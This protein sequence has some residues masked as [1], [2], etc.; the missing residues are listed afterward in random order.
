MEKALDYKG[1]SVGLTAMES[2]VV[3]KLNTCDE[4]DERHYSHIDDLVTSTGIEINQLRG[5][6]SSLTKKNVLY[7]DHDF[8]R[9]GDTIVFM[10]QHQS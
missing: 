8:F 2:L 4:Y 5:V 1:Q 6:L 10:F 3:E 7:V 9:K